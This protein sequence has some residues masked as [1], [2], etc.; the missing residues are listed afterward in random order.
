VLRLAAA[1]VPLASPAYAHVGHCSAPE[2][3]GTFAVGAAIGVL[4]MRPWRMTIASLRG[5]VL[6][7]L[8]PIVVVAAATTTACGG[9]SS[10]TQT[11]ATNRPTTSAR[12]Q[13]VQPTPN[14][15][16]GPDVDVE[17]KLIGAKVVPATTTKGISPDR[18][19]IHV[20]IDGRLV[21]MT[22]GLSQ[23]LH[24]IKPGAHSIQ[25]E[26]VASDHLPFRNRVVAAVLFT[27][28]S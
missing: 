17:L 28:H 3:L 27:V 25:A 22:Y 6:R 7:A 4:V 11:S 13:I 5:R 12:L 9:K 15:V 2:T 8:V 20:S 10:N 21:S 23:D 1:A 16:T 24:G 18:G 26:F 14:Q 19:H